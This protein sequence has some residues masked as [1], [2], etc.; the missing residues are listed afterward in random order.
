MKMN[1]NV[2]EGDSALIR[3]YDPG[4]DMLRVLH[5]WM[6]NKHIN[7]ILLLFIIIIYLG[8]SVIIELFIQ[9]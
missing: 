1:Y 7:I 2:K 4:Y 6:N 8:I 5:V 3:I 9:S